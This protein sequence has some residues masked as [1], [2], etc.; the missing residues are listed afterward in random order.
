MGEEQRQPSQRTRRG[1]T[2]SPG[3]TR[4]NRVRLHSRLGYVP[5]LTTMS[6]PREEVQNGDTFGIDSRTA[7]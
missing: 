1:F 2:N 4:Y 6:G 7:R 5:P 3:S